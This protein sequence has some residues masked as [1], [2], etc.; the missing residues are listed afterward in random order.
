MHDNT[1][2]VL[3]GC[4][5]VRVVFGLVPDKV[6][7]SVVGAVAV[8]DVACESLEIGVVLFFHMCRKIPFVSEPLCKYRMVS[9]LIED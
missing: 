4:L 9:L 8:R 1:Y 7:S 5:A 3:G 6:V 2:E